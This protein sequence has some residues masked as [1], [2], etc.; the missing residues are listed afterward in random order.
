[1]LGK[2]IYSCGIGV[3]KFYGTFQATK[4]LVAM[5]S[6]LLYLG[7]PHNLPILFRNNITTHNIFG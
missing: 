2:A 4:V 1:M 5:Y 7:G 3:G 6:I